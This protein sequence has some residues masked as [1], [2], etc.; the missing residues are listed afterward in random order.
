M[1]LIRKTA[2]YLEKILWKS[3]N[4]KAA[5]IILVILLIGGVFVI[6]HNIIKLS[7]KI[8]PLL[9]IPV[10]V[11]FGYV[12][13]IGMGGLIYAGDRIF[14]NL[15]SKDIDSAQKSI[16]RMVS[17]DTNNLDEEQII[18]ATVE[19][20]AENTVDSV[21]VPL[22]YLIL[23]G[24][25]LAV[26][27]KA[28]SLLDSTIGFKNQRYRDFGW[29]AAKLDDIANFIPARITGLL[30]PLAALILGKDFKNSFKIMLRDRKKHPSPNSGIPEA[31]VAGALGIQLGGDYNEKKSSWRPYIGD[32]KNILSLEH[33]KDAVQ[34]MYASSLIMFIIG[35]FIVIITRSCFV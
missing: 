29:A 17:R 2:K 7:Y 16:A 27:A 20:I 1:M 21:M 34:L 6:C 18:C 28:I 15:K 9:G 33:I 12:P 32:K 35:V 14:R 10:I 23:G 3:H 8:S 22:F 24:A 30:I 13:L 31:A 11:F 4:K 25:P 5:G 26:S 19:S